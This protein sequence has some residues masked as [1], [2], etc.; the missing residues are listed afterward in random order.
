MIPVGGSSALHGVGSGKYHRE[1]A[2][3][4]PFALLTHSPGLRGSKGH[5]LGAEGGELRGWTGATHLL[6][7]LRGER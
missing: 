2:G 5:P 3:P 7:H 1:P 4:S 6:G